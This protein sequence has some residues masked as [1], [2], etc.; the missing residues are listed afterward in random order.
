MPQPGQPL[1]SPDSA[2]ALLRNPGVVE[3][4]RQQLGSSGLTPDQVRARLRAA[5]YP[6]SLLDDYLAGADSTRQVRPGPRTFDAVR[7]LGV[8]SDEELDSLRVRDSTRVLSDSLQLLLDSLTALR[9]DSLRADSLADS[10]RVLRPARPQA[11][12]VSR[13]SGG[14]AR[15]FCRIRPGR[16]TRT[17]GSVPATCSSSSSPATWSRRTASR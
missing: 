4:L 7:A 17:T 16:W 12:S 10:I 14:P 2:R 1:P 13:P 8:L 9:A 6:E 11:A 15:A 5:G 3:Q